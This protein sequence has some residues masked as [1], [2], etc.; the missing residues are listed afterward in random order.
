MTSS[1]MLA[2][3][4]SPTVNSHFKVVVFYVVIKHRNKDT[5]VMAISLYYFTN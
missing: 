3:S 5:Y 1:V 4:F 2:S